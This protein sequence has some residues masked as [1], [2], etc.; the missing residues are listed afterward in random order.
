MSDLTYTERAQF[1]ATVQGMGE[2][3]EIQEAAFQL[4]LEIESQTP[5]PWAQ[6]DPFAAERYLAARGASPAAAARNAAGFEVRFRAL[7]AL[8]TGRPAERFE[9]I[10]DWISTHV[11]G[12]SR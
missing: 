9:D 4:I 5:A 1:L 3:D 10:A 6:S 7:V 11:D 8:G 12:G 2:G